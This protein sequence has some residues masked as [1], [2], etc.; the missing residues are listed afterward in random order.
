M[1]K[2]K[3]LVIA[4]G[5]DDKT[6]ISK[7]FKAYSIN[8]CEIVEYETNIHQLYSSFDAVISD[9]ADD[10]PTAQNI[11][12][13]GRKKLGEKDKEKLKGQY[14]D[15]LLVFDFDPHD[16]NY[17]KQKIIDMMNHF[18]D[19]TQY[20]RL[21]INYPMLESFRHINNSAVNSCR[22]DID[23]FKRDF[24]ADQL[25]RNRYKGTTISREG[26]SH[27]K[28]WSDKQWG[29]VIAHHLAKASFLTG[30]ALTEVKRGVQQDALKHGTM[31]LLL[32]KQ[33]EQIE[34]DRTGHVLNTSV[35]YFLDTY[36]NKLKSIV[37]TAKKMM[38]SVVVSTLTS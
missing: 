25:S 34:S 13:S 24:N 38:A 19:S 9:L 21:Y 12:L 23:F 37:E 36:T 8:D 5:P 11:L 17:S 10:D 20:G 3:V 6:F 30:Q 33:C 18:D 1:T 35:L 28:S 15:V 2:K 29:C 7:L 27:W 16:H 26:C 4:E 22:C 32:S 31:C 14:T